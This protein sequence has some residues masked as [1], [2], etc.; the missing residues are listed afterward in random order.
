MVRHNESRSRPVVLKQTAST[1]PMLRSKGAEGSR[2]Q[3]LS[4]PY[5]H[6]G[7]LSRDKQRPR[8]DRWRWSLSFWSTRS[9]RSFGGYSEVLDHQKRPAV[10]S[11]R[12]QIFPRSRDMK[13]SPDRLSAGMARLRPG[14]FDSLP[15]VNLRDVDGSSQH[16]D[17]T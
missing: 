2:S 11:T 5:Q 15:E 16:S 12:L 14:F 9:S 10:G 1:W 4:N 3:H 6:D 17:I 8:T 13:Y 7:H